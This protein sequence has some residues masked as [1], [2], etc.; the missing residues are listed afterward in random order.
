MK[1]VHGGTAVWLRRRP[2]RPVK[3]ALSLGRFYS[4]HPSVLG[5]ARQ[6]RQVPSSPALWA[7][8]VL[9]ANWPPTCL[10]SEHLLQMNGD[11]RFSFRTFCDRSSPKTWGVSLHIVL[12]V[13]AL[14]LLLIGCLDPIVGAKCG[15]GL[16]FCEGQCIVFGTYKNCS[17]CGDFCGPFMCVSGQCDVTRYRTDSGS[18][19]DDA[20]V[21]SAIDS[22]LDAEMDTGLD[23]GDTGIEI[24]DTGLP[25]DVGLPDS[26]PI[27]ELQCDSVCVASSVEHC[28]SCDNACGTDELCAGD[29]CV[30]ECE[31]LLTR[32]GT[33]CV[34]T[35]W[36]PDNCGSCGNGCL[37]G[38]CA[39]G[40]CADA[41]AGHL[42]VIGH[43]YTSATVVMQRLAG[44]AVFLAVGAPV[45]VL[46]FAGDASSESIKGT[47]QA[48]DF[49]AQKNG[50]TWDRI[51][52]IDAL[53][54]L[55]LASADVFVIYAQQNATN[56]ELEKYG[57]SWGLALTGFLRKGG[58]V[59]LFDGIGKNKGTYQILEPAQIFQADDIVQVTSGTNLSVIDLSDQIALNVPQRYVSRGETVGFETSDTTA[60][61]VVQTLS[62]LPVILHRVI[63]N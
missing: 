14:L 1:T 27:G 22:G 19:L 12:L 35:L 29:Q 36:D 51:A 58:I 61:V 30:G 34:D 32:C 8:S 48:I 33:D 59:V 11:N 2:I 4:N 15:E 28:G 54:T 42:V 39:A 25:D 56:S 45:K 37:S 43:N 49:V 57:E 62:G 3:P 17:A 21:D 18:F 52:A 31:D 5:P 63:F 46:V 60:N 10:R 38:I 50:R 23:A 13:P 40:A 9:R 20:G 53:V 41:T 6:V 55:Q 47:D 24:P 26:C 16:H 7:R 44:N